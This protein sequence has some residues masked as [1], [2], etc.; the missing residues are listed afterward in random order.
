MALQRGKLADIQYISDSAASI[1]TNASGDKTYV[2]SLVLHNANSTTEIVQLYNVPDSTGSL[3]T[4]GDANRF[5]KK[6][7]AA[8]ETLFIDLEYPIVLTDENDSIQAVTTTASKV[9]VQLMGDKD[10]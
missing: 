1:L 8:D 4:A 5:F 7:I 3:G 10:A 9:T 6:D 2:R